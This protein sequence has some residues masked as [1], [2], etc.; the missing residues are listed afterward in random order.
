MARRTRSEWTTVRPRRRRTIES[1]WERERRETDEKRRGVIAE[2][3]K[4]PRYLRFRERKDRAWESAK[5]AELAYYQLGR[6]DREKAEWD[7][8]LRSYDRIIRRMHQFENRFLAS[9]GAR[10]FGVLLAR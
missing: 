9:R 6:Q 2:M 8:R 10:P 1:E 4:D 3:W 5:R 7:R